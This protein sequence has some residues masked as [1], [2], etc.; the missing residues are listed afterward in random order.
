LL[1]ETK[2]KEKLQGVED[3]DE[4]SCPG[5]LAARQRQDVHSIFFFRKR[6]LFY[7]K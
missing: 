7:T 3:R 5:L 4:R 1:I 2:K 6:I